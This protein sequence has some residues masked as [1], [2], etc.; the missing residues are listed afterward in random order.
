MDRKS[1][2]SGLGLHR[3]SCAFPLRPVDAAIPAA[4][5]G[6]AAASGTKAVRLHHARDR[7]GGLLIGAS[8]ISSLV[9]WHLSTTRFALFAG[10]SN[11]IQS[12]P[13]RPPLDRAL[14]MASAGFDTSSRRRPPQLSTS[15][16]RRGVASGLV[17][18]TGA[19]SD[20]AGPLPRLVFDQGGSAEI[21]GPLA[22]R[23]G[24]AARTLYA[25]VDALREVPKVADEPTRQ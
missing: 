25:A 17:L 5:H 22:I 4:R 11:Q 1:Q 21:G 9:R 15:R 20:G 19:G 23:R 3:R 6:P 10:L 13:A 2:R 16:W 8:G 14:S 12:P 18:A 24:V 7:G